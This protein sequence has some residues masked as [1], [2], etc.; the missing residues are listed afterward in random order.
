MQNVHVQDL[1]EN[2]EAENIT[3]MQQLLETLR[4]VMPVLD[5]IK[6]SVEHTSSKI[7]KASQQLTNVTQATETATIE[8]L[9]LLDELGQRFE[10]VEQQLI[11]IKD[12]VEEREK[13]FSVLI[14]EFKKLPA[15]TQSAFP[16]FAKAA[17]ELAGHTDNSKTIGDLCQHLSDVREIS[18]NIAMALQVQDITTQQI[19]GVRHMIES[20][21]RQLYNVVGKYHGRES[22]DVED[23]GQKHFDSNASFN[24]DSTRQD[25]ADSIIA[26]FTQHP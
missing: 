11:S 6:T 20:V 22:I 24:K 3:G 26:Q 23:N 15:E 17:E 8:I 12:I 14:E 13:K 10:K 1:P 21:R 19:E 16:D 18:M 9:N 4:K 2:A 25:E 7:P 5:E